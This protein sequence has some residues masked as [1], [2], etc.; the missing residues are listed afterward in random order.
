MLLVDGKKERLP[1]FL[2]W[3]KC[4]TL[5][6][7]LREALGNLVLGKGHSERKKGNCYWK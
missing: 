5:V 2:N 7:I 4:N 6:G 3:N 1:D